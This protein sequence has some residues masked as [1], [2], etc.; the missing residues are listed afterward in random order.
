M[1]TF[2]NVEKQLIWSRFVAFN[3]INGFFVNAIL[4]NA[5]KVDGSKSYY[6]VI[7]LIVSLLGMVLNSIWLLINHRGWGHMYRYLYISANVFNG[8]KAPALV[9]DDHKNCEVQYGAIY[10]MAQFIPV[11]FFWGFNAIFGMVI[12]NLTHSVYAALCVAFLVAWGAY[13]ILARRTDGFVRF[14][15]GNNSGSS[16]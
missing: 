13:K 16:E 14:L 4:T 15:G 10:T 3:V 1:L 12:Y 7:T 2:V 6:F 11:M 9:T 8:Y 5:D